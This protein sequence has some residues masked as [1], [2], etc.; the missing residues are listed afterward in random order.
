VLSVCRTDVIQRCL[1]KYV[2]TW[3]V[4][5]L[6]RVS[7]YCVLK[8]VLPWNFKKPIVVKV[9]YYFV[10]SPFLRTDRGAEP[11]K[12][13]RLKQWQSEMNIPGVWPSGST[14]SFCESDIMFITEKIAQRLAESWGRVPRLSWFIIIDVDWP[15]YVRLG[16]NICHIFVRSCVTD[17]ANIDILQTYG[18]GAALALFNE[19]SW[20]FVVECL[21]KLYIYY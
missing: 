18:V 10:K 6:V 16:V 14:V 5:F 11:S 2:C 17:G 19:E 20:S 1:R 15:I 4:A 7:L 8:P 12:A 3:N 13:R 9:C 21:W